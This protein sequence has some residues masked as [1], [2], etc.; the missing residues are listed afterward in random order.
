MTKQ[1]IKQI[2]GSMAYYRRS[3]QNMAFFFQFWNSCSLA[4]LIF[5]DSI[6]SFW[7]FFIIMGVIFGIVFGILG[8]LDITRGTY[9]EEVRRLTKNHPYFKA[10]TRALYTEFQN[11][12]AKRILE[13]WL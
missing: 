9:P 8:F 7:R 1:I 3:Y 11:P 10:L 12:E 13:E 6:S 5:S 2:F 4:Y